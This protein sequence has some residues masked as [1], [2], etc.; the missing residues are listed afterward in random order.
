MTPRKS[1][2]TPT[3]QVTGRRPQP[4]QVLDL[5]EQLEGLASGPVVLVEE[6]DDRDVAGPAHLEQ[7]ERLGLHAA[8]HVEH[9]DGGVG[10][11]QDPVGVLREVPVTGGVEQVDHVMA[12]GE[13][14]DRRRDRDAALLL[15][16]HPVRRG[17]PPPRPGLHRA[18]LGHRPGVQQELLGEGRLAGV[19][20]A[21][22]GERPPPGRLAG[23]VAR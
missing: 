12:V 7:L 5:V 4:D 9:H 16:R 10:G 13:L 15:E 2:G 18:G 20:M 21:D 14:Q 17:P 8:G 3:G 23:C 11:G 1:P 19:G 6:R 22:D